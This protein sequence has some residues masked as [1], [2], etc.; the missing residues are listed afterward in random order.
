MGLPSCAMGPGRSGHSQGHKHAI[1]RIPNRLQ[2]ISWLVVTR[3]DT[4]NTNTFPKATNTT[5]VMASNS[6]SFA[7][8]SGDGYV[9][10]AQLATIRGKSLGCGSWGLSGMKMRPGTTGWW[11]IRVSYTGYSSTIGYI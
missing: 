7:P 1:D 10:M 11:Y 2:I 4:D 8:W 5:A 3:D 9:G 6:R